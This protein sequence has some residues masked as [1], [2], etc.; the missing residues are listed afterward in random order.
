MKDYA[1]VKKQVEKAFAG[2]KGFTEEIIESITAT[3]LY[4]EQ[5]YKDLIDEKNIPDAGSFKFKTKFPGKRTIANIFMNRIYN[6]VQQIVEQDKVTRPDGTIK[7]V[8]FNEYSSEDKTV[9]LCD[10]DI[11]DRIS[12]WSHLK[13]NDEQKKAFK[14]KLRAKILTHELIHAGSDNGLTTGFNC[15][16]QDGNLLF[17][18]LN[19]YYKDSKQCRPDMSK[20]E[21]MITEVLALRIV[22]I[23]DVCTCS[24][25]RL[26][27]TAKNID[28]SNAP[29][30]SI[31][32]YFITVF[33]EVVNGKFSDPIQFLSEFANRYKEFGFDKKD[34]FINKFNKLLENVTDYTRKLDDE[35][36]KPIKNRY[37]LFQCSMLDIYNKNQKFDSKESTQK[38]LEDY[39]T[40]RIY[41]YKVDGKIENSLKEKLDLLLNNCKTACEKYGLDA[42]AIINKAKLKIYGQDEDG[43]KVQ[44]PAYADL[45]PNEKADD[46]YEMN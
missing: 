16:K 28:S 39:V 8:T 26:S 10:K 34:E 29:I 41:A 45:K 5:N 19:K 43:K 3:Y 20:L 11:E 38:A 24:S 25:N 36:F 17:G 27:Y 23:D 4:L 42:K 2:R 13:L 18:L 15:T 12:H 33:P 9:Y 35:T 7:N 1:Q 40:F 22:G 31:A 32:E 14:N 44:K 30:Y 21:E 46:G 6:N 37:E